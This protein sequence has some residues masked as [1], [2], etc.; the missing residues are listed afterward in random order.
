MWPAVACG[1]TAPITITFLAGYG[2]SEQDVPDRIKQAII[3]LTVYWYDNGMNDDI[4][5][6]IKRSLDNYRIVGE[7]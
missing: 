2:D 3:A 4:P 5:A 6:G 1:Y 7:L